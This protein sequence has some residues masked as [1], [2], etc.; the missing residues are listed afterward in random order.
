MSAS[1]TPT[2]L[3]RTSAGARLEAEAGEVMR[4]VGDC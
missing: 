2:E 1:R 3:M 4:M